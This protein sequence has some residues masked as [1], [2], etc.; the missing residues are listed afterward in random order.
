MKDQLS[1]IRKEKHNDYLKQKDITSNILV[2]ELSKKETDNVR[3]SI[4]ICG[5]SMINGIIGNG[6]SS[7]KNH[8]TVRSFSGATSEDLKDYIKPLVKKKPNM[9]ILHVGTNDLSKK[10]NNTVENLT[11]IVSE[12]KASSP[13]TE[14]VVSNIC[15]R[16]DKPELS[17]MVAGLNGKISKFCKDN[18]INLIDNGK[19]DKSL[20]S[21]K[22]LH[23]SEKGLSTLAK[24]F[25]TYIESH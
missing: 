22:R 23:L 12:I 7:K 10:M 8:T 15:C 17:K 4:L 25:K 21:K 19:I 13:E 6:L 24:N 3:R 14:V 20:L 1:R 16:E 2:P 18:G 11:C 5:D 9:K